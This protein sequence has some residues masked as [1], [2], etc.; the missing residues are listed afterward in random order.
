MSKTVT[1]KTAPRLLSRQLAKPL[2]AAEIGQV[3]GGGTYIPSNGPHVDVQ[4]N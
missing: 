4:S 1:S 3:S 2:S